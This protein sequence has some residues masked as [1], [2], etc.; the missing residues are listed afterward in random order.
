MRFQGVAS[1]PFARHE[2]NV[3][4]WGKIATLRCPCQPFRT[5]WTSNIKNWRKNCNFEVSTCNPFAQ[6][7]HRTSKTD[8]KIA[9]LRCQLATLS[10]EMDVKRQKPK[11]NCNFEVSIA[12]PVARNGHRTSK[13]EEKLRVWDVI[14]A[15]SNLLNASIIR[16]FCCDRC[17]FQLA[18]RMHTTTF[19]LQPLQLPT[20]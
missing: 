11:K 16:H 19:L 2:S 14:S 3:R 13:T 12:T 20:C 4:N 15:A 5:K 8:E 1:Y 17:S 10:H 9:T 6:N 7:G 18:T